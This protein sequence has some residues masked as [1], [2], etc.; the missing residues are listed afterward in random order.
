MNKIITTLMFIA[1]STVSAKAADFSALKENL[2]LTA[3]IAANQSVFGASAKETNLNDTGGA[4]HVK[5]EH[6][7][8]ADGHSSQ[9]IELGIGQWISV[10]YEVTPDSITTPKNT[11]REGTDN[12]GNV[13]VD[14]NDL[15]TTYV[16]LNLPYLNGA[17]IK[18]GTVK[19]DLDIK[20]T[21]LSG[22][23]Y[24]NRSTDGTMM[25]FGYQKALGDRGF[26]V[27]FEGAY[28]ELDNVTT[29]NGA[30]TATVAN[31]GLNTI[32]AKNLE[33]LTGK[34]ALT[35]TLGNR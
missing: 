33:G 25:A 5:E 26:A 11:S 24:S 7:V 2:S 28:M 8:F 34:V 15:T 3:G 32:D 22:S 13:S 4:G 19:T 23:T 1:L 35:F 31:G 9:F 27:R 30:S 10:G 12:E 16:K 29:N 6:G 18:S 17:Y 14:F 20:E 21:M